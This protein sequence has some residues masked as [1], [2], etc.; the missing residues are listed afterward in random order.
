MIGHRFGEAELEELPQRQGIGTAPADAALGIDALEVAD[1]KYVKIVVRW[2][3]PAAESFGVAGSAQSFSR[4]AS[5]AFWCRSFCRK[6]KRKKNV[7]VVRLLSPRKFVFYAVL[8][9]TR[10]NHYVVE[11]GQHVFYV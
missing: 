10:S 11:I 9:E 8:S 7:S 5:N 6:M 2:D 1:Q 3:G 4:K